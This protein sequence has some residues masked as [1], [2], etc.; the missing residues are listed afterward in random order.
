MPEATNDFGKIL[1]EWENRSSTRR[2]GGG[3]A[4]RHGQ[5]ERE[6]IPAR[7]DDWVDRY[8]PGEEDLDD[9]E[10][11]HTRRMRADKVPIDAQLDLHGYRLEEAIIVTTRFLEESLEL[12]RRK[13]LVI[14]GKGENGEGVL[15]REIRKLLERHPGTGE[16][17]YG[18][19]HEGGRGALWVMLRASQIG[20]KTS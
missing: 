17:G 10:P 14:H 18:K 9:G 7:D 15:R 19:G 5:Q 12:G 3:R 20:E 2:A 6:R 13:I 4:D 11:A 8:L 16:M 1:D